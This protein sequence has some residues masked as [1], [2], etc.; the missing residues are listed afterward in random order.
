MHIGFG[1]PRGGLYLKLVKRDAED[2]T[3]ILVNASEY[4]A[5]TGEKSIYGFQPTFVF[6]LS[7]HLLYKSTTCQ[8]RHLKLEKPGVSYNDL[9]KH[10]RFL[11]LSTVS[12]KRKYSLIL[13]TTSTLSSGVFYCCQNPYSLP[14]NTQFSSV[15][16]NT[17]KSV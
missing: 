17:T 3:K 6:A 11:F 9:R 12:R 16:C 13:F 8:I 1:N 10:L 2:P 5:K 15:F 7:E 4:V 14:L